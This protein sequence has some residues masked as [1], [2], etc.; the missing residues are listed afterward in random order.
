MSK[1]KAANT[2]TYSLNTQ[3]LQLQ[4]QMRDELQLQYQRQRL[5]QQLYTQK[6]T[7]W[8]VLLGALA[9]GIII[10]KLNASKAMP[11]DNGV[12]AAEVASQPASEP[13]RQRAAEPVTASPSIWSTLLSAQLLTQS[14]WWF[15]R[16]LWRW[17]VIE[18]LVRQQLSKSSQRLPLY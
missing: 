18:G 2:K 17:G 11:A 8:P 10:R 13:A 5:V 4:L 14:L 12:P 1:K 7:S 3:I 16:K 15:I 9:A 6:L